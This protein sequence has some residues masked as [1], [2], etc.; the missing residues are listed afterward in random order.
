MMK[1]I[2]LTC[3]L[4]S[5]GALTPAAAQYYDPFY[6]PRPRIGFNC[7]AVVGTPYGPRRL[8]CPIVQPKPVGRA[9]ACPVAG[10]PGAPLARGRT[11]R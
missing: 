11:I 10:Y 5:V 9:C 2:A 6:R 1:M 4:V 7:S 8:I 3:A